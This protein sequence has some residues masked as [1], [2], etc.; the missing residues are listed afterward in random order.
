MV[1]TVSKRVISSPFSL[2]FPLPLHQLPC[3]P[4]LSQGPSASLSLPWQ[5]PAKTKSRQE[6]FFTTMQKNG[7]HQ[8][9]H[10]FSSRGQQR[11]RKLRG[12]T[13]RCSRIH[14]R[15]CGFSCS[16]L[17]RSL[18]RCRNRVSPGNM[19]CEEREL[20]AKTNELD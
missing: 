1:L 19:H 10:C 12:S 17:F 16:L 2:S 11:A 7:E 4:L 13:Y 20:R 6:I 5:Q 8:M 15:F 9:W 18:R 3:P 14:G